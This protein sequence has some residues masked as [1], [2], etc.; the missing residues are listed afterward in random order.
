MAIGILATGCGSG[1]GASSAS[2]STTVKASGVEGNVAVLASSSLTAA[3]IAERTAFV[4][5]YPK[6][7]VSLSFGASGTVVE[8]VLA[9]APVDVVATDETTSLKQLTSKKL[10]GQST[11]IARN[12]LEILVP[13]NNPAKIRSLSDLGKPGVK[14][15]VCSAAVPCGRSAASVLASA[16]VAVK[17]LSYDDNMQ[18]IVAKVSAGTAD[19]GIVYGTDALAAKPHASGVAIPAAHNEVATTPAAVVKDSKH[20]AAAEAF[21][22]FVASPAGQRIMKSHGFMPP[23]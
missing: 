3:F 17:S 20:T 1:G 7:T 4:K 8:Q 13:A 10:I 14:L 15:D 21:I 19:A 11:A 16:K 2:P 5:A 22:A 6:A 18:A 9:K 23:V 12:R